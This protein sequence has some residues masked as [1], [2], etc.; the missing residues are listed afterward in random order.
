MISLEYTDISIFMKKFINMQLF[1]LT[2]VS[3]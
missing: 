2:L 3:N 1:Y